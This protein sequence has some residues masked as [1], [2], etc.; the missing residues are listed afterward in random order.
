VAAVAVVTAAVGA[1][2]MVHVFSNG[3]YRYGYYCCMGWW[4]WGWGPGL[5]F[6][7]GWWIIGAL[8]FLLFIVLIILL[9][10]WLIRA[11]SRGSGSNA[12][13]PHGPSCS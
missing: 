10:I 2:Y 8:M 9:I 3:Y 13:E 11:I 7:F 6:G 12:H 5:W 1:A 4:G